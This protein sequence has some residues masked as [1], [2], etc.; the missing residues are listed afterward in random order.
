MKKINLV[1]SMVTGESFD[2]D[3]IFQI[4]SREQFVEMLPTLSQSSKK[5]FALSS[6]YFD[7]KSDGDVQMIRDLKP[8]QNPEA[9][10]G[11]DLNIHAPAI[12]FTT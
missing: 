6:K 9:L 10:G 5:Y 8:F 1:T 4:S 2:F 11:F 12:S 7:S 3:A